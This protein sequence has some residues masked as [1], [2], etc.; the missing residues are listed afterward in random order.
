LGGSITI[1]MCNDDYLLLLQSEWGVLPTNLGYAEDMKLNILAPDEL[2]FPGLGV[3]VGARLLARAGAATRAG[4]PARARLPARAGVAARAGLPTW[5]VA[6]RAGGGAQRT[7]MRWTNVS[8]CF[9]IRCMCQLIESG[10][11]TNKG[12]KEVHLNQDAKA[13]QEFSGSDVT[14]T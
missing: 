5:A 6:P 4:L 12:F 7:A 8:S 13:L 9:V 2:V 11:R 3:A 10:V 1:Y 14:G